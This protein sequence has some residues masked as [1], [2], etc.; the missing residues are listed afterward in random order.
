[1]KNT[2]DVLI[3]GSGA[4]GLALALSLPN[5]M[6]VGVLSKVSLTSGSTQYAQGGV[7]VVLH[8]RD[9]FDS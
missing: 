4:A 6:R 8:E 1:M 2:Y 3:I 5:D 7:S 9:T